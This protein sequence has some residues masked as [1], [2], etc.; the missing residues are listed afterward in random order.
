MLMKAWKN[1]S[2]H[3]KRFRHSDVLEGPPNIAFVFERKRREPRDYFSPEL[4]LVNSINQWRFIGSRPRRPR[5]SLVAIHGFTS[6]AG[7]MKT[8]L[9]FLYWP[10]QTARTVYVSVFHGETEK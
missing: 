5:Y 8:I 9:R 2:F 1:R 10:R 7:T 3:K 6:M 4:Y